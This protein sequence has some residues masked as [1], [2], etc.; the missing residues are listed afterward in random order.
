MTSPIAV[1]T[2]SAASLPPALADAWGIRTVPL[3]VIVNG[4]SRPEGRDV[5]PHQVLEELESGADVSTSQPSPETFVQAF[6]AAAE[7]GAHEIVVVL[8]SGK[9]SG[10]VNAAR[11]AAKESPVPVHVV[12][13]Q[14]L[15]MAT[16][17]SALAAAA[18]LR[19]GGT[20]QDA[21]AEAERVAQTSL[22]IFTVDTLEYMVKGGR[23]SPAIA[24]LGKVLSVR[25]VL[26]IEDG[27]VALVERV[28][29]TAKARVTLI[30][31]L[32]AHLDQCDHPASAIMAL[33]DAEYGDDAARVIEAHVPELVKMVRTPVSAVLAV[34][35]GP[36][37]LAGVA[38][39]M[40][41]SFR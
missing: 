14:T 4:V 24:A 1:I 22:C 3:Q 19:A 13:S 28:R 9:M 40:P 29:T 20:A 36:G 8:I 2:D 39:D 18:A 17:Y 35:T 26:A 15:A 27:E 21:V 11:T 41:P 38:V 7:A 33:G 10:T 5:N 23:I 37:A 6:D 31:R 25:P 16:G 32:E 12:D 30:D 34:H